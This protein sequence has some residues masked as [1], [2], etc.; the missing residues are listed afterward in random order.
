MKGMEKEMDNTVKPQCFCETESA[1]MLEFD[2]IIERLEG[3]ACTRS[4]KDKI[5]RAH[6]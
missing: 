2:K 5:G 3:E 4:A 1:R 6:V